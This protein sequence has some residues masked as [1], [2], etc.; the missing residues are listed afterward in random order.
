L[1]FSTSSLGRGIGSRQLGFDDDGE[2]RVSQWGRTNL[3]QRASAT[4]L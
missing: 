1:R 2:A 3:A 4:A